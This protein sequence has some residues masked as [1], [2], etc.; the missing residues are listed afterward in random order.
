MSK[1]KRPKI[2]KIFKRI[3]AR[4]KWQNV[5]V[6]INGQEIKVVRVTCNQL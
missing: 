4:N 5:C 3:K 6:L 1:T 2:R